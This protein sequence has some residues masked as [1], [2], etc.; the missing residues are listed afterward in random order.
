[1]G[2]DLAGLD[3]AGLGPVVF[4]EYGDLLGAKAWVGFAGDEVLGRFG[5]AMMLSG[6]KGTPEELGSGS[7]DLTYVSQ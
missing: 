2:R 4:G 1:M 5:L 3:L 6:G 7:A